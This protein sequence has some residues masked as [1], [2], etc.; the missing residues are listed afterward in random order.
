M[1]AKSLPFFEKA[2]ELDKA[3]NDGDV[4]K[5]NR[6]YMIILR[7]LYH[8]LGMTEKEE[9]MDALINQ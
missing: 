8:R 2:H 7:G 1:F 3:N 6:Q 5:M 4:E 9:A